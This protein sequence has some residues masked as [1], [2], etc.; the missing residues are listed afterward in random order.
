MPLVVYKSSAGSGKTTTLVKSYLK[1]TLNNPRLFRNVLAI[2]FTN[3]A[4]NEMKKKVLDSLKIFA[5]GKTNEYPELIEFQNELNYSDELMQNKAKKL[6]SLIIHQYDEFSIST[7]DSFVHRIIKTFATDVKLPQNFDVVI[8]ED[9]IIPEIVQEL[10]DKVGV[11]K[12]ITDILL[13][14]VISNFEDEK[15]HDPTSQIYGFIQKQIKEEG[16][17]YI[18]KMLHLSLSDF[19]KIISKLRSELLSY[20]KEIREIGSKALDLVD[21]T[22]IEPSGFYQGQRGIYMYF[23]KI[24]RFNANKELIP[25]KNALATIEEDKWYGGKCAPDQ[26][27]EIDLIKDELQNKFETALALSKKYVIY[28]LLYERIYDVALIKEIRVLFDDYA[29]RNQKVHIS[30]FNKKISESIAEQPVPFIYERLGRRY[31]YFLIDEFQDTSVLQWQN[32]LPLIEESLAYGHFNMLVGDAKQAIY[33][34]RNGEVELFSNLPKLYPEAKSLKEKTSEKVLT[35]SYEKVVLKHNFRSQKVIIDFNNRFF[36]SVKDGLSEKNK[37]VYEGHTQLLPEKVDKSGGYVNIEFIEAENIKEYRTKRLEKIG[38]DVDLLIDKGYRQKDICVLTNKNE[39][40]AEIAAHLIG[41]SYR[42]ISHESLLLKNADEVRLL[43]AFFKLVLNNE[44][45]VQLA[46]FVE[47]MLKHRLG[48]H[49]FH[50]TYNKA[51]VYINKGLEAVLNELG[52]EINE[53]DIAG[54]SAYELAEY[55]IETF[56]GPVNNNIFLHYFLDFAFENQNIGD[57]SLASFLDYWEKKSDKAYI[58]MPKGKDAIQVM[59]IHKAKGL[60]FK[61]VIVDFIPKG[62]SKS[63]KDYWTELNFEEFSELEVGMY[64]IKNEL[65][66]VGLEHINEEE[67]DKTELDLLNMIYVAFTRPVSALFILSHKA[68]KKQNRF[69]SYIQKYLTS[70]ENE[71]E[72]ATYEFGSLSVVKTK[73]DKSSDESTELI[74]MQSSSWK[75]KIKIA[76]SD[77]IFWEQIESKPAT[78]YGKLVHKILSE[79]IVTTDVGRIIN[80]YH[81]S[82]TIDENEANELKNKL[83]S[84]V[85]N[86]EL[87]QYFSDEVI[88]RNESELITVDRDGKNFQRPDRVVIENDELVIIDYKTGEKDKK[89]ENQVSKYAMYFNEL[90][91]KSVKKLLVYINE[92]IEIVSIL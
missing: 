31:Q 3:K 39:Y 89:H 81:I 10:Y 83:N 41:K 53:K 23:I 34:F 51:L 56:F 63:K 90:G 22:G 5:E 82:G 43:V 85:H 71:R 47:N 61:S 55:A 6:L 24:S 44:D 86:K 27:A 20:K 91:Y 50:S 42:V 7:I 15:G 78:T 9:E 30:E 59:T 18:R 87:S 48:D 4:A 29:T 2:T 65:D 38:L 49:N 62:N 66:F 58:S 16:F 80:K 72:E 84:L 17:Q 88:I 45:K 35:D 40:A 70:E 69:T 60:K 36:E 75:G 77:E 28:N 33:R 74:N 92:D 32:F 12:D 73:S 76:P 64:P 26:K 79:I 14:F 46:T 13:N 57:G 25:G 54:K 8:D 37:R 67:V 52:Y 19:Q 11:D 68:E 21:K 1:I